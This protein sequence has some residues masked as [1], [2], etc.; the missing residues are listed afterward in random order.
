MSDL[1][2]TAVSAV[3]SFTNQEAVLIGRGKS[4]YWATTHIVESGGGIYF[5]KQT[6]N[7]IKA[8]ASR[9]EPTI[10]HSLVANGVPC[11]LAHIFYEHDELFIG[12]LPTIV[13][14]YQASP[15][16]AIQDGDDI[17]AK[18]VKLADQV[19]IAVGNT[20]AVVHHIQSNQL[21]D[22]DV[23]LNIHYRENAKRTISA[24]KHLSG[25][26]IEEA[27]MT[28]RDQDET[29]IRLHHNDY[30]PANLLF[31]TNSLPHLLAISDWEKASLGPLGSD[32]LGLIAISSQL[33]LLSDRPIES[34]RSAMNI[35][36][37]E[38]KAQL[39]TYGL[40][41]AI[42]LANR[43]DTILYNDPKAEDDPKIIKF[44]KWVS[45]YIRFAYTYE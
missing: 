7:P 31:D 40:E 37:K 29:S 24:T 22:F 25:F 8:E 20:L 1:E 42:L 6:T 33:C 9:N 38:L 32:L 27:L 14:D 45:D 4:S 21:P 44:R 30:Y 35:S 19:Q 3:A 15:T 17:A 11:P 13:Y 2:R 39:L 5:T 18:D 34:Y 41:Q 16:E 10:T 12:S 43:V 26:Q 36:P 23:G 28:L